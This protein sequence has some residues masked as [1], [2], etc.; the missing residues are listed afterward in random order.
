[1]V[2]A[3]GVVVIVTARVCTYCNV[4]DYFSHRR[5]GGATGRQAGM[6]WID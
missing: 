2:R 1:M 4:R 3:S 5:D 6:A